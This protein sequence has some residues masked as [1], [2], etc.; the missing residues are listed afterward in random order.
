MALP[1]LTPE[2]RQE[3]LQKAG[4]ARAVRADFKARL[5]SGQT[6]P[7]DGLEEALADET[8]GR[9]RIITFLSA[10]PR[11]GEITV[12]RFVRA[13]GLAANRSL[14]GLGKVQLQ[15]VKDAITR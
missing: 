9:I 10:L 1:E 12:D 13:N 5:A 15:T 11:W 4:A 8:L 6:T 7:I 2:Q 3:A 14:R